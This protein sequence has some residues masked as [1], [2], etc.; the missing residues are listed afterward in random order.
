[1]AD[2][3]AFALDP[4]QVEAIAALDAGQSVL[5]AAPTGS[6]KTVVAEHAVARALAEGGKAFYTTPIKALSNQKYHDLVAVHGPDRVGLLTG[7][8]AIAG[9]APVVVMTT[10]VLRNM[11]YAGSPA[12]RGLRYVVLDEVHYLQDAYRGPVWEEVIVHLPA[13]VRLV[14]LSATVSN[15]DELVAWLSTVRGPTAQVLEARRPIE[16][17]NTYLVEDREGDRLHHVPVLVGGR[18]NPEGSRFDPEPRRPGRGRPR[19]RWATPSRLDVVDLL[20]ERDLL[21]AIVFVFS[22]S[23]CNDAVRSCL[24]AGMRLTTPDERARIRELAERHVA[25]LSDDD[26]A[27]LGYGDWLASLEA[28]VAAHHAGM[29]PPFKEAVE[30]CF[31]EG[32][33]RVVFATETLALGVNMPARTVVIEKLTKFTGEGHEFLTPA[34][35]TQLTGRAGRRGIDEQGT[36]VVLWSPFVDFGEVA[37]LAGSRSFPLT[38]AF[39]P[40]YNMAANLVRRYEPDRAHHLLNLSFAQYQA[41]GAVVRLEARLE[42]RAADLEALRDRARCELGDVGE[43]LAL[44]ERPEA[45]AD[46]TTAPGRSEVAQALARLRPGDVILLPGTT[47]GG[48]AAVLSVSHRKGGTVRARVVTAT[49]KVL[50]V[51]ESDLHEPPVPVGAVEL[52]SPFAPRNPTFQRQVAEALH[53]LPARRARA[54]RPEPAHPAGAPAAWTHPVADCPDRDQHV[55]AAKRLRRGEREVAD[56]RRRVTG[57]S[58][59]LA[60]RFDL[61]LGVLRSW[62]HVDGWTL[63]ARGERL[64]R[65]FHEADLLIA[66]A[67]HDG[68]FDGLDV[69]SVV[70]LASTFTYEHRAPGPAPAPWFPPGELAGRWAR[71]EQLHGTLARAEHEVGLPVTRRPDPGFVPV[72][73]GWAAGGDLDDVLGEEEVTPGDFV[74]NVK[75]LVDLL[76][77]IGDA[78]PDPETAAA[79][80]AGAE[81]VFRGV[82]AASAVLEVDDAA[83]A[84]EDDWAG[85]AVDDDLGPGDGVVGG[86]GD[87]R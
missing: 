5:V 32:L 47:A 87:L 35:Y 12:L 52:P 31:T 28:G 8:N 66:E 27:V 78:A 16:L 44:L 69:P 42:R 73:H 9:D 67:L 13:D 15:A 61:V 55:R 79:A 82:V 65:I 41:D 81:A 10:E 59:S 34:Q 86:S 19:R 14:C 54:G 6:G 18:P 20:A 29:V 63:T 17:T 62:G 36:A 45:T 74:R 38:S 22:R 33:V 53:R 57:H 24:A 60:R 26:L 25:A 85:A 77:Q 37:G 49:R 64:V 23:G 1:M 76:R 84:G 80:R 21:P 2:P 56:L 3:R 72:A 48:R 83:S 7:D 4:F 71:L 30:A 75:Q 50:L 40:T 68:I 51:G 39:R 70:A 43:Y 11:I 58:A 46:R